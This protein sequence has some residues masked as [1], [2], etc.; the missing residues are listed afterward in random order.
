MA[1]DQRQRA[2]LATLTGVYSFYE[3]ELTEFHFAVWL[4]ATEGFELGAVT[5]AFDAHMMDPESG[6][7]L[8]KPADITK[9]LQGTRA[10]RSGVAW[11]LVLQACQ[12]VG[13]YATVAFEDPVVHCVIEDL[14]GWPAV[15]H[16]KVDELPFLEARFHK[17]YAAHARAATLHAPTLIGITDA[18]NGLRG[19]SRT[20]PVL[21]GN[22]GLA[23]R[24][25]QSGSAVNR[26]GI[27]RASDALPISGPS[28]KRVEAKYAD[29][30]S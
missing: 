7:W 11:S 9:V 23:M 18:S 10:E 16:V 1:S 3:K 24:T 12:R 4:R 27:T 6:K 15:C 22:P 20:E 19:F 14:G 17:S 8:P 28:L 2:L 21:I 25:I 30:D 13:A 26:I 5:A 29:Q